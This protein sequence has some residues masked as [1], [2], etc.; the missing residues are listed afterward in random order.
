MGYYDD[1][2]PQDWAKGSMNFEVKITNSQEDFF[3]Q[4]IANR[5]CE[6]VSKDMIKRIE[7]RAHELIETRVV[8]RLE[9]V[10][11]DVI[12][13][14][15]TRE[16]QPSDEFSTPKGEP[17]TPLEFIAKG[18]EN[19][20]DQ[21]VDDKGNATEP[22]SYNHTKRR[23]DH[24]MQGV[25]TRQFEDEINKEVKT[26]KAEIL[27]QMKAAASAWLAKFQAETATGIENA[28][29]LGSTIK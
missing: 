24:F 9:E 18:A 19:F 29:A 17:I 10:V 28:K 20:L 4:E 5:L 1:E 8:A 15:L 23:I 13:K 7:E 11:T 21:H 27:S 26:I 16:L 6:R 14:G 22:S 25:I 3:V 12:D 2:E